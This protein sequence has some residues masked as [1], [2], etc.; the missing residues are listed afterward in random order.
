ME[1]IKEILIGIF[2]IVLFFVAPWIFMIIWN[3]IIPGVCGFEM[4]TYWQA[5]FLGLGLRF[6][7]GTR[8]LVLDNLNKK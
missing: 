8:G 4:L 6:I 7:N 2:E 5:F 1:A 3:K